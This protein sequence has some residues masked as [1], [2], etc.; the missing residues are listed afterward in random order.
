MHEEVRRGT[1]EHVTAYYEANP[2]KGEVTLVVA[3]ASDVEPGEDREE[4]ARS[5]AE[6]LL[7]QGLKPSKAAKEVAARLDLARNEAYRI[8]HELAGR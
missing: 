2:P 3:P 8:V 5:L 7:G 1:L 6:E 4:L